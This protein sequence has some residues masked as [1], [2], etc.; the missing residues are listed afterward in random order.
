MSADQLIAKALSTTSEEEAIACLVMARKK[1]LKLGSANVSNSKHTV[2]SRTR[3]LQNLL[4]DYNILQDE[5]WLLKNKLNE[6][7]HKSVKNISALKVQLSWT[8]ML[9]VI[10]VILSIMITATI[11][12]SISNNKIKA[13]RA[14]MS[15]RELAPCQSVACLI[16]RAM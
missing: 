9:A 15:Q 1:G 16:G 4:N 14:E 13:L 11:V 6:Q 5:H 12:N 7:A 3:Q 8:R 2:E 10:A